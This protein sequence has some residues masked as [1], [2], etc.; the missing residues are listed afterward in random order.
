MSPS[1]AGYPTQRLNFR[2]W[3]GKRWETASRRWKQ[4]RNGWRPG[5]RAA[6]TR[7][8]GLIGGLPQLM[9]ASSSNVCIRQSKLDRAIGMKLRKDEL[10]E[11]DRT[12]GSMYQ[13]MLDTPLF[14][15]S[16]I[17]KS[18]CPYERACFLR[19]CA[20]SFQTQQSLTSYLWAAALDRS[21]RCP[22]KTSSQGGRVGKKKTFEKP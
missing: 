2:F 16:P 7:P 9:R 1:L 10:T 14:P 21:V 22:H 13:R 8:P 17:G 19:F 5:K 20:S 15:L 6:T 3:R 4:S 18:I 11:Y 12:S